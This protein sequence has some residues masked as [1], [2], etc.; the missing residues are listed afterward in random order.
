MMADA[1]TGMTREVLTRVR[2]F[3]IIEEL[4]L[5]RDERRT[6]PQ[7]AVISAML[8]NIHVEP[9]E[10]G[11]EGNISAFRIAFEAGDPQTAQKVTT[12]LTT[13]FIEHNQKSRT[14]IAAGT[15]DF[16][17][18]R[19]QV[20]LDK[21]AVQEGR[22]N[23]F[24]MQHLSELPEQQQSTLSV[25]S[26]L[27]MQLQSHASTAARAEELKR[28][29]EATVHDVVTRMETE[30]AA[31]L[32]RLTPKHPEIVKK[33]QEIAAV[34]SVLQPG[35][36]SASVPDPSLS[37]VRTQMNSATLEIENAA[38]ESN[39]IRDEI[40]RYQ[41]KLSLAPMREQQL[42]TLM[43]DFDA[44]SAEVRDLQ[45]KQSESQI[46]AKVEEDQ[47]G[48]Q[49]RLTDP[50]NLPTRPSKPDRLK[51]TLAGIGACFAGAIFLA[52]LVD[53]RDTSF[54]SE[55][56]ATQAFKLP[57]VMSIPM[58]RTLAQERAFYWKQVRDW[59]IVAAMGAGMIAAEVMVY[60]RG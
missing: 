1:L 38:R 54:H 7:E 11:P 48:V 4:G 40:G 16:M 58:L 27:R 50:P 47:K 8:E 32:G 44:A 28:N 35:G 14:A 36:E 55:T 20:A 31:L 23:S 49:F 25:L 51:L 9:L 45:G 34:K 19:L 42:M 43:R 56:S 21:L 3:S 37:R 17:G 22:L 29:A 2:I 30:R 5:Y 33:D 24:R 46:T 15:N 18:Q 52:F 53:S 13:L 60:L 6:S 59:S 41:S 12:R 26:D 57:I 39:R 10:K